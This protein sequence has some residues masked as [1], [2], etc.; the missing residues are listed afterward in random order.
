MNENEYGGAA[1]NRTDD[2]KKELRISD[3]DN[4]IDVLKESAKDPEA[5]RIDQITVVDYENGG[6]PKKVIYAD[7]N[8]PQKKMTADGIIFAVGVVVFMA[9]IVIFMCIA[10]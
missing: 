9:A 5:E 2:G 4:I 7:H 1:F 3:K 6:I 10:K 8:K